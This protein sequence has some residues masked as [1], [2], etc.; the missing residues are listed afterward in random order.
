M[1]LQDRLQI[2]QVL[3]KGE[4]VSLAAEAKPSFLAEVMTHADQLCQKPV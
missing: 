2:I 1:N 3:A 4:V